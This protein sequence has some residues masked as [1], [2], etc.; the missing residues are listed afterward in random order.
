MIV[1]E[2]L[3]KSYGKQQL[4]DGVSFKVNR[5]ERVGVVG[6]NGH[7]KTTLFRLLAGLEEPDAGMISKPRNYSIGYVSQELVFTR[8]TVLQEAAAGLPASE[9]DQIWRV[10]KVLTGLGFEPLDLERPPADLSGGFQVRLN[11]A[12]A[13]LAEH[14]LLLLDEPNNFLDII[15]IRWLARTLA[16]WPGELMLITHDRSFM[17]RVVTHVLGLHRRKARKIVGRTSKYYAQIVQDEETYEKTRIND[18]RKAK[19]IENFIAKFRASARLQGLVE[20]RKKTLAKMGKKEKLERLPSL[21]FS[22]TP[23]PHHGKYVMTVEDLSFGYEPGRLLFG[24]LSLTVG[25]RDRVFVVGANGRGKTTLLKVLAGALRPDR[26]EANIPLN[27]SVGY[28]E[29]S[30]IRTLCDDRT[31]LEEVTSALPDGDPKRA[32]FLC[33]SM[34]FE[35][36]DALKKI[37]VLSG[38]EKSRVMLAKLIAAPVNLLLLDEPSNHLDQES[39]DA[40]LAALDAFEGAVVMVT[41]NEL[42]L[43]AL[44]ERLVVFEEDGAFV[45]EGGYDWFLEKVGWREEGDRSPDEPGKRKS[46]GDKD[47]RREERRRRS[48]L[49]SDRSK[50]LRPLESRLAALEKEL[51]SG[52]A[53]LEG[54][55]RETAESAKRRDSARIIELSKAT[56]RK[57][58]EVQALYGELEELLKEHEAV[59]RDFEER[60]AAMDAGLDG[61]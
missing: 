53:E 61:D 35:G 49:L 8:P 45:F 33:G 51:E 10:E 56:H 22:F 32:R 41:H 46:G 34:M 40:L 2:D 13:L 57:K 37:R 20:S 12:K 9:A 31:V 50:A 27:V 25:A 26:G 17:D 60:L 55:H 28:F 19:E 16:S 3:Y 47:D 15:S 59:K 14:N 30:N 36:D 29:Q 43:R 54:M 39:N 4:F 1:V 11:L 24:G 6:R 38:G 23:K 44:A 5:R 48:Q 18:E 21:E 7:G 52:E 58:E 42:F